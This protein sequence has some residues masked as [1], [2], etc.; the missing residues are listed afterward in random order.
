MLIARLWSRRRRRY[1]RR[2]TLS[3]FMWLRVTPASGLSRSDIVEFGFWVIGLAV[4]LAG[5]RLQAIMP[6]RVLSVPIK[7]Y[8]TKGAGYI[9]P[10][11]VSRGGLKFY[12][13]TW[14][15]F[16]FHQY[17]ALCS[18]AVDDHQ[19]Y[20]GDNVHL[21]PNFHRVGVKK[22]EIWRR[23]QHHSTLSRRLLKMQQDI[24]TLKQTSCVV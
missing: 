17:I 8:E 19:M 11:D 6:L 4:R 23:F 9:R 2:L 14:F 10:P 13:W 24:R 20:S 18:R 3:L 5:V 12:P 21:S 1:S 16:L 15:S 7:Q 22:C